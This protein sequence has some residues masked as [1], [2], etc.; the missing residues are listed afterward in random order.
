[1]EASS[2]IDLG[3]ERSVGEI[4][5]LTLLIYWR[6]PL[7]FAILAFA[8]VAPYEIA[9]LV[10]TGYGPISDG[11]GTH[12]GEFAVFDLLN[13]SLVGPLVSALHI[14][15][16]VEI[17]EGRRP[18]LASVAMQGLRVLPV[19]A[20]AE[21]V[22]TIS[23]ALGFI[24][25]IVPGLLLAIRLSVVAQTAA[26][27]HEGW[28]P[29]L[30]RS[31]RLASGNYGHIFGL[32]AV[33]WAATIAIGVGSAMAFSSSRGSGP[34]LIDHGTSVGWV[35]VGIAVNTVVASFTA[36]TLAILY[37]DLRAGE[38]QTRRSRPEYQHLRD[39]D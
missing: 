6:Y 3:R 4:L 28:L 37:F 8:V 20:A 31:G 27:D 18:K 5:R 25:F 1:V 16:V 38:G 35:L 2:A 10:V 26:V 32:L 33:V 39:L 14:H 34:L 19:V 13:L 21:I 7:L 9:R 17:G 29:A 15:A 12:V 24:A 36:L 11:G 30:R 23:I 22:A